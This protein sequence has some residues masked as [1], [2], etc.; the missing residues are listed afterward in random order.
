MKVI[1]LRTKPEWNIQSECRGCTSVLEVS[2]Q[3]I[4]YYPQDPRDTFPEE[5]FLYICPVEGCNTVNS[6][7]PSLEM[8]REIKIQDLYKKI[9]G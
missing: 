9:I 8:K 7:T 1:A 3:D 5:K 2:L 6:L 4:L